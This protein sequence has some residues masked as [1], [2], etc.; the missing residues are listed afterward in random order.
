[1]PGLFIGTLAAARDKHALAA[2]GVTHVLNCTNQPIPPLVG[3]PSEGG[4]AAR[5]AYLTLGLLDNPADLPRMQAALTDGVHFID[6]ALRAGGRV[7]VHCHRG[8]SRSCT[9]TIAYMMWAQRRTAEAVFVD[10]R[11]KR[12]VADPNLSYW[13]CLKEW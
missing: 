3:S 10:V 8:I 6:E 11:S 12:H 13:V 1:M 4:A 7:L 2:H 9:L 5:P